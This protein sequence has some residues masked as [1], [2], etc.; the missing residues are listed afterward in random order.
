MNTT[1]DGY[2]PHGITLHAPLNAAR[3]DCD[4]LIPHECCA[5]LRCAAEV[6][7]RSAALLETVARYGSEPGLQDVIAAL[8]VTLAGLQDIARE[9]S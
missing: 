4:S 2:E 1:R 9:G 8:T 6:C 3:L 7:R 5:S